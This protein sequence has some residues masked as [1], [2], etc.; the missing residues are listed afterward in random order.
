MGNGR[1][2]HKLH[3]ES[4]QTVPMEHVVLIWQNEKTAFDN[5]IH[6]F[7]CFH[8]HLF[9]RQTTLSCSSLFAD[10]RII[11]LASYSTKKLRSHE[12]EKTIQ[13]EYDMSNN[14]SFMT[15]NGIVIVVY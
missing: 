12:D 11:K 10:P 1:R 2:G 4:S 3:L 5:N 14:C 15:N 6:P 7:Q 8:L 9:L 13:I